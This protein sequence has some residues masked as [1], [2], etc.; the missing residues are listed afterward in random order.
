MKQRGL[1]GDK[2]DYWFDARLNNARL[3]TVDSYH[4][5]VPA[6]ARLLEKDAGDF[7]KFYADVSAM[8]SLTEKQRRERLGVSTSKPL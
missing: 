5:L 1:V 7:N 4:G 6:F 8:K 2:Y 3:A